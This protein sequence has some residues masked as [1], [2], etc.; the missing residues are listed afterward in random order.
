MDSHPPDS[1]EPAQMAAETSRISALDSLRGIAILMVAA[2]HFVPIYVLTGAPGTIVGSF[3][4]G[5]VLLFFLL[6]GYLI[7]RNLHRQSPTVFFMRRCFKLIPAYWANVLII[8]IMGAAIPAL[9]HYSRSA[10][11]ANFVMLQDALRRPLVNPNYWTLVIELRFYAIIALQFYILSERHLLMIPAIV[12]AANIG[13]FFIF[14]R[15]SVLLTHIPVFYIGIEIYR[16][17]RDNWSRISLLRLAAVTV[18]VAAPMGIFVGEHWPIANIA[19]VLL[20]PVVFIA[21]LRTGWHLRILNFFG[22]IS[23]SF[24]LFH[25]WV[26]GYALYDYFEGSTFPAWFQL[27]T[28]FSASLLISYLCFIW[29]EKPGVDLGKWLE[30]KWLRLPSNRPALQLFR[31]ES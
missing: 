21:A 7:F 28:V 22:R 24:Y 18:V 17:E 6:S 5:G 13:F 19:Y 4:I 20:W 30:R 12:L 26:V 10:F 29:V 27:M 31:P 1:R 25:A 11:I 3:G 23:Y 15:G 14:G 16:A 9:P 2:C 8:A